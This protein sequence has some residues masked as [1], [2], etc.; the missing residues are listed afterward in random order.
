MDAG[1]KLKA[2][3]EKL[4]LRY[5]QVKDASTLI[6]NKYQNVEFNVGLARLA[7]IENKGMVP[8]LHRLY[9]LCAIYKLDLVE[10]LEWYGIDVSMIPQDSEVAAPA[11]THLVRF[12]NRM[13]GS[14]PLPVALDPG[15]NFAETTYLSRVIR[16]WGPIPLSLLRNLDIQQ[17]RY[18]II[19]LE[20]RMMYPLLRP[21]ALV[22]IDDRLHRVRSA[23]WTNEYDRPIY[24]FETRHGYAC[25]W[26][27]MAGD[28]L[29]LQPH[30]GS[31]QEPV[32]L[33]YP[34]DVDIVGQVVGVAMRLESLAGVT[35]KAAERG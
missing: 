27:N 35:P 1:L 19:G 23:G 17:Y 29:I 26:C 6:A 21:G 28:Q 30:P 20:D 16:E 9:S 2:I 12:S 10:V 15:V 34:T 24:F 13:R 11:Q 7:D 5:R 3:R 4:G 25:G 31:Q 33:R 14:V 22:Q 8:T 32:V 18:G